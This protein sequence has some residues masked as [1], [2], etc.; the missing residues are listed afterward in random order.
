MAQTR[1]G[2]IVG[3]EG[4]VVVR[5]EIEEVL[6]GRGYEVVF[7]GDLGAAEDL[8]ERVEVDVLL[9]DIGRPGGKM[10]EGLKRIQVPV[11][12]VTDASA[13]DRWDEAMGDGVYDYVIAPV[14]RGAL[15]RAVGRAVEKRR[16]SDEVCRW[17][18]KMDALESDGMVERSLAA[19]GRLVNGIVHNLN[20]PL[21]VI[22]GRAELLQMRHPEIKGLDGLVAQANAMRE[23]IGT[24]VR[25]NV[26]AREPGEQ[27]IDLNELLILELGFLEADLGFKH[28][29]ETVYR[30]AESLPKVAGVYGEL[31]QGFMG[32]IQH[33]IDA[34]EDS[35]EKVLTVATRA[36]ERFVYVDISDTGCGISEEDIARVFDPFFTTK[37]VGKRGTASFGS[38]LKLARRLLASHGGEVVVQSEVGRGT[39]VTA[40][41]PIAHT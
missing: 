34:M 4:D 2:K 20:G 38:G 33:A 40:R 18:Q 35:E 26:W 36:D 13:V 25:R 8:A 22:V 16:L 21:T 12:V 5:G 31:S 6:E 10:T 9:V 15:L 23:M 29:V 32:F 17:K 41:M 3:I 14:E 37:P 27:L 39:K 28:E 30:L 1:K 7:V 11:V 24:M 19:V